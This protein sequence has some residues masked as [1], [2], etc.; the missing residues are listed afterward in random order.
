MNG[1]LLLQLGQ[2]LNRL[3]RH[4]SVGGNLDMDGHIV[5]GPGG[6]GIFGSFPNTV[7]AAQLELRLAGFANDPGNS[8]NRFCPPTNPKRMMRGPTS[9]VTTNSTSPLVTR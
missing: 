7:A 8:L 3:A 1:N 2:R 4:Q 5:G 6:D 9:E